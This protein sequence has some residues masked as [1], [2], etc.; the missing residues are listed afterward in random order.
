MIGG[1][2]FVRQTAD[3]F[4]AAA[5]FL[6]LCQ[7]WG[8]LDAEL[9]S[10]IKF[11]KYHAL[12]IAKAIKAGEDPN[13]SNPTPEPSPSMDQPS[14]NPSDPNVRELSHAPAPSM[15][16]TVEDL[17][18]HLPQDSTHPHGPSPQDREYYQG[19]TVPEVSPLAPPSTDRRM[20]DGGGYFPQVSPESPPHTQ[21]N[22][23]QIRGDPVA[24]PPSIQANDALHSFPPP[25]MTEPQLS[26]EAPPN[27][28]VL[29]SSPPTMPKSTPAIGDSQ[30][31]GPSNTIVSRVPS[32]P[33]ASNGQFRDDEASVD[34]A[35]RHAKF[36]ISALN[37]E[38]VQTGVEEL[39]NALRVLGA[40]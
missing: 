10:K 32:Q 4:Q 14:L 9:G 35:Q 38:D 22:Q 6:E 8:P 25:S 28:S 30:P 12:R 37:F 36:A 27:L 20:S 23:S 2:G 39:R 34:A 33:T 31:R 17:P 13:L 26:T 1:L 18:E 3:T 40:A 5:T 19:S 11:A 16:P 24:P 29:H 15:Q 7:I 21:D